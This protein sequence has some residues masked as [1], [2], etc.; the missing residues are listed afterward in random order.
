MLSNPHCPIIAIEEHYWDPELA[1][2]F[3]GLE[4]PKG[5]E[6]DKRLYDFADLRIKEMDAAGVDVQVLS[7]GAP[8]AQKLPAD[9][10]A[11]MTRAV[12]DRLAAQIA[13]N[14]KRFAGF[15]AL[16]TSDVKG[17]ADEMERAVTRLGFKGVMIHGTANGEYLDDRKFWPIFERAEALDVPIYLHPAL[18]DPRITD[19]YLKDYVKDFPLVV[20][21]AWGYT[22]D[23]ATQAIRLVLSGVFEKHP[24]LK[25]ILGHFGETLPFLLWRIDSSLKRPG[26][27][28]LEFRQIFTNN[29]WLTTSGFF[30]DPALLCCVMEMGV[31]RLLFAIDWP[32]VIDNRPA[33]EWLSRIPLSGE[34]KVKIASGNAKRLLKM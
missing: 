2:T 14:P 25:I 23:T 13:A 7:H 4:A 18:P 12:N 22:I 10:A 20:R 34:D 15:A 17:A 19:I 31:D 6:I 5:G 30:S 16:P 29:F 24:K 28:S 27:K 3:T 32:F 11:V 33:V 26:Q 21:P 8:S 1:G 9:T